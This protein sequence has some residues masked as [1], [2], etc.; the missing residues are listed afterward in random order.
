MP[1]PGL[2]DDKT[3]VSP[4]EGTVFRF[5]VLV[6]GGSTAAYAAALGALQAGAQVGLVQPQQVLG[7]QFTAQ[8]LPASDDP[9]LMAP[10]SCVPKQK[11]DPY[12]LANGELFCISRTQRV[13]R[14]RQRALQPVAGQVIGNPGGSWVSH[15]SVTPTTAAIAL[16]E[17][18]APYLASEQLTILAL[19]EPIEVLF[20]D[21]V[22][23][24]RQVIGAVFQHRNSGVRFTVYGDVVIEATDL[25]DLLELGQIASRVGQESRQETGEAILPEQPQP[26]CQQA[27]TYCAVVEKAAQSTPIQP[28]QG[29]GEVGW[30]D[31]KSF[32]STFWVRSAQGWQ[33]YEFYDPSGMFRYRRLLRDHNTTQ[34]QQGDISV[35]NWATSP[36]GP[37]LPKGCGND[38]PFGAVLTG[39]SRQ[40]RE[41]TLQ[42][43]RDRAQAYLYWL[44]QTAAPDLQPRGDLTW[45]ADGIALEPYIR[46]ARRG[47]ALTTI[48]HE[49]VAQ[50]FFPGAAR[51]R[52][53]TDSVGIGQYHYLDFHPNE[54][55]GHVDLGADGHHSLPFTIPLGSLIPVA[56]D[57]LILSA[58]S[59]GTT[60]ITN[61]AY[62]MHPVE[63]A[64][65]EAGGHLAAFALHKGVTVREVAHDQRLLRQLQGKLARFGIPLYWF[66]D[67]SHEDPDFEAI[68]VLAAAGIFGP[69][70]TEH[71]HCNPQGLVTRGNTAIALV[72][73]LGLQIDT[74][75]ASPFVDVSSSHAAAL[76]IEALWQQGWVK[77]VGR[78]RFVPE[79]SITREEL[80]WIMAK[81]M[82]AHVDQ[83]FARVNIDKRALLRRE[84]ARVL[85][86]VLNLRLAKDAV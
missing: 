40:E 70:A 45:T 76:S 72:A 38:Y 28:P 33:G 80:A 51:A 32:P 61:A 15:F 46:E 55:P 8:G 74:A 9:P 39:V 57:G 82:P 11:L 54:A 27:F 17:A 44:Q 43:G 81:A 14:D 25:G 30:L 12:R 35:M 23:E 67:L 2:L 6:V 84:L 19:A 20:K 73:A 52:S 16:N 31:P 10:I 85:Y 41:Q 50:K 24:P 29:Y 37:N 13:F 78:R 42:R 1:Q 3:A 62:R 69:E 34:V 64:I 75:P 77:G 65:G 63:W 68:Q 53:F 83:L 58:K 48:R 22:S 21:A 49:D 26:Q 4:D 79:R 71:L 7:G 36:L 66:N 47:V 18:I 86:G 60:H 59:I 56:T 5:A